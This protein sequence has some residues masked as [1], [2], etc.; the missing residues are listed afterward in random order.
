V[1][2][3]QNA[4]PSDDQCYQLKSREIINTCNL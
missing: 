3:T 4:D 1:D 2:R